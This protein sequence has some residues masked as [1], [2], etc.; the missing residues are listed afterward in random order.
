MSKLG[1]NHYAN[2]AASLSRGNL[3]GK[4]A[5]YMQANTVYAIWMYIIVGMMAK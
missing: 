1:L 2:Q 3:H 4:V 5:V